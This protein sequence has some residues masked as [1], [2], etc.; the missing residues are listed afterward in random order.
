MQFFSLGF[1]GSP[2]QISDHSLDNFLKTNKHKK[3]KRAMK[4]HSFF[5]LTSYKKQV[6]REKISSCLLPQSGTLHNTL[7]LSEP[8]A[9]H[10]KESCVPH[11]PRPPSHL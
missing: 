1:V 3:K 11:P 9:P 8:M 10:I 2:S 7:S 6:K 5:L 4:L